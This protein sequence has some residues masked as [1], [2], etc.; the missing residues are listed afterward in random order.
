MLLDDALKLRPVV[1]Y[2]MEGTDS[3]RTYTYVTVNGP[4]RTQEFRRVSPEQI[5]HCVVRPCPTMPSR[6]DSWRNCGAVV[7]QLARVDQALAEEAGAPRGTLLPT[8]GA[9]S[10]DRLS[11]LLN[12]LRSLRGGLSSH[13]LLG[14]QGEQNGPSPSPIRLQSN[15]L[16][17]LLKAHEA[18]SAALAESLG[19]SRVTLGLGAGGQVSRPDSLRAWI[20]T[21]AESWASLLRE[22][23]SR[24]LERPFLLDLKPAMA[25]LVPHGQLVSAAAK[26]HQAGWS[27]SD[28]ERLGGL[29]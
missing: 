14:R 11:K 6:G 13:P 26:L 24:V 23:L 20:S 17:E 18:L 10:P 1:G 16:P 5:A 21:T 8:V 9:E 25:K 12:G 27:R 4:T 22:E 28:A 29:R 19:F 3:R 15:T 7:A 2:E